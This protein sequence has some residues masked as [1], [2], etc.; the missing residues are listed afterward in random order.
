M[1]LLSA[2]SVIFSLIFVCFYCSFIYNFYYFIVTFL[3]SFTVLFCCFFKLFLLPLLFYSDIFYSLF[4]LL[5]ALYF[6]ILLRSLCRSFLHKVH[7]MKLLYRFEFYITYLYI[8]FKHFISYFIQITEKQLFCYE[9]VA[10]RMFLSAE[11]YL[12][13]ERYTRRTEISAGETPEIRD[14]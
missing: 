8:V 10:K 7:K 13:L 14:A 1:F 11:L 9:Q 5:F 12:A 2:I 6:S 3:A 4:C